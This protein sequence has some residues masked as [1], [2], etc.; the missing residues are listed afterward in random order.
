[1]PLVLFKESLARQC[2]GFLCY[3]TASINNCDFFQLKK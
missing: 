3:K 1:M 2:A